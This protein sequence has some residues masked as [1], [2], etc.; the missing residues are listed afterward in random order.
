MF[1][2]RLDAKA[3]RRAAGRHLAALP[4]ELAERRIK[5]SYYVVWHFFE[6]EGISLKKP[7]SVTQPTARGA[8]GRPRLGRWLPADAESGQV[9]EPSSSSVSATDRLFGPSF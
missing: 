7:V 2:P 5:V 8:S 6:Y 3:A 1:G 9:G 4:A